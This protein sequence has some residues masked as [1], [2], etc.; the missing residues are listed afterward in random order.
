MFLRGFCYKL[1][2]PLVPVLA[3]L[4]DGLLTCKPDK[5]LSSPSCFRVMVFITTTEKQTRTW[6]K[7]NI[8]AT[9]AK[10]ALHNEHIST[11]IYFPK[12]KN[13][14]SEMNSK[15]L[16]TDLIN[17]WLNKLLDFLKKYITFNYAYVCASVLE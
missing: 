5:N 11:Y 16:S 15:N 3:S 13:K 8:L 14:I 4:N 6:Y 17:I 7:R 1:Y 9:E 10:L 2:L 12:Q